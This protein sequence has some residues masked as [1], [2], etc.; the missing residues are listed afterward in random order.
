MAEISAL[1]KYSC[2]ACGAQAEWNPSKQK[3]VCGF[4]GTESPYQINRDTGQVAEIDL[5]ATLRDLPDED[6]GWQTERRSVQCQSCKAV[7]VYDP[8]RVGQNCEFC[9]S[10]ALVSYDEI[11]APIRPHGVLPFRIDRGRVR[12]DI[13]GWW[14]GKWLAPNRLSKTAMVDTVHSLYIPY[15]TFDARVHCPWQ[16]EAGHYY[17]VSV[18]GRDGKGRSVT[19]QERRVRWEAASGVVDHV[20]DDEP[21]PGTQGLPLDLLRKVEPFP[22]GESVRYDAAFLAGHVVEHYRVVLLEAAQQSEAQMHDKLM[23]MCAAQVP[24]DTHRNLRIFPT[25]SART[26]KHILVPIWLLTYNYGRTAYQVLVNGYTGKIAG[27]HPYSVWKILLLILAALI[28]LGVF[29]MLE[30]AGVDL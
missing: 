6:R 29:V 30:G 14:R 15:W 17:Y 4:C 13:R 20:F 2:P 18:A 3:L 5:V 7:M 23:A 25:Y 8:Q 10:P 28:A 12:D 19:R 1:D 27:R 11:K 21:V 9:G 16:A 24:G 26:F 22:T